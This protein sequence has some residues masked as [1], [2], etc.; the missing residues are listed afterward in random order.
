MDPLQ[1]PQGLLGRGGD[2]GGLRV[3]RVERLAGGEPGGRAAGREGGAFPAGG[4]LAEQGPQDLD[5][6][7]PLGLRGRDDLGGVAADVRQP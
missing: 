1:G 5:G 4:F 3:P 6:F 7:P 2:R